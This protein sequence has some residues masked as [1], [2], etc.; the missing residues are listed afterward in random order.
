LGGGRRPSGVSF[1]E[2][3]GGGRVITGDFGGKEKGR[4]KE[5]IPIQRRE[6]GRRTRVGSEG[7]RRYIEVVKSR[8]H[9]LE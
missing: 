5:K 3:R 8:Q 2:G 4:K 6:E 7:E 1:G 9:R